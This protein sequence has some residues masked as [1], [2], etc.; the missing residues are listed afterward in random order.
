MVETSAYQL[1]PS[2]CMA[3]PKDIAFIF[4]HTCCVA[5]L[6]I[7]YFHPSDC[8]SWHL[9]IAI[10]SYITFNQDYTPLQLRLHYFHSL[11]STGT[12]MV[13]FPYLNFISI[14][15]ARVRILHSHPYYAF[16]IG[17]SIGFTRIGAMLRGRIFQVD[18]SFFTHPSWASTIS[19][20]NY[21]LLTECHNVYDRHFDL[22]YECRFGINITCEL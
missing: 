12:S 8:I 9:S 1:L 15:S 4:I 19:F 13:S 17:V 11:K 7:S 10:F 22:V 3:A 18:G 5:L 20:H 21:T 14:D 2:I 16:C 6:H